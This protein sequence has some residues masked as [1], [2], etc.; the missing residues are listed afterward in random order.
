M[1]QNKLENA[2]KLLTGLASTNEGWIIRKGELAERYVELVGDCLISSAFLSYMGPF[3]SE[4]R[5]QL[6]DNVFTHNV[7]ALQIPHNL[8]FTFSEFLAKPTDLLKW[9]FQGLPSDQFS[10]DNGVLVLKGRR[11]A[12]M[13]DP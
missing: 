6:L 3:P 8:N 2:E 4:Y 11:F 1:L 9:Q 12:L 5:Q 10:S 7:N 13:I